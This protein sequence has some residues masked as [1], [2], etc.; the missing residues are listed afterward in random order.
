MPPPPTATVL[1]AGALGAAMAARLG[2][3][4]HDVRLWNRTPGRA[5]AAADQSTGVTAVDALGEAVAGAPTVITVLRDGEA[6]AQV[7]K[8]A[9]NDLGRDTVWVQ[10]STIGPGSARSLADLAAEHG[11][12]FLDAPVS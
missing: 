11:V 10:A 4:G 1:G 8:E 5:H 2:E 6:V 12:A 7:M 3:S 9:I